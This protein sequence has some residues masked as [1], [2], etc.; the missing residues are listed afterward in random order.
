M[1]RH[2]AHCVVIINQCVYQVLFFHQSTQPKAGMGKRLKYI[3]GIYLG[4]EIYMKKLVLPTFLTEM[5]LVEILN[6]PTFQKSLVLQ[7][8]VVEN[9]LQC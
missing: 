9:Y 2:P 8:L 4:G 3:R 1:Q 7:K 6:R 5:T